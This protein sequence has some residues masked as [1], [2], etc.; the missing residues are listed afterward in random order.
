MKRLGAVTL[1]AWPPKSITSRRLWG[2]ASCSACEQVHGTSMSS[3][4]QII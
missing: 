4:A 2:N 1:Q 3:R